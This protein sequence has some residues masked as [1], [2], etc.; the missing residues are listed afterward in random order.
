MNILLLGA[1]GSI[2]GAI[3]PEL[4]GAGHAVTGL[5]R[6]EQAAQAI[7][8]AGGSILPG[9]LRAP[10]GWALAVWDF[11]AV[12][13]AAATFTEDMGAVD[14]RVLDA[15]MAACAG[16]DTPLRLI[17]TGGCWL[18]GATGDAVA[19]E[20][21]PFD[22]IP[23]FAW[24]VENAARALAFEGFA[25][26]VIHPAMVYWRD[27]GVISRFLEQ[28]R[29]GGPVEVWGSAET[30]WPMVHRADLARAY[31]LVLESGVA[32]EHYNVAVED[33]VPVG[34][35]VDAI[36]RRFGVSSAPVIRSV[37]SV[38]AEH[39]AWAV[40]PT[41]DQ[42]MGA[43]KIRTALGWVPAHADACAILA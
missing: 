9:D 31:R 39:G 19:D 2:G 12:I 13:H 6:S 40:G 24:M 23:A 29:Q 17:Y 22:P 4:L 8:A 34:A 7:L 41:L 26:S 42:R 3:L 16:R 14:A 33:G 35:L 21:T 36:A 37:S 28:A 11:D 38:V 27:G 25:T 1:T 43:T 15:L 5:A 32:G 30:R 20:T 10:E 18:Y